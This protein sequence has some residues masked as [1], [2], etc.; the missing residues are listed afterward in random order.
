VPELKA[1]PSNPTS[2]NLPSELTE[3][4]ILEAISDSGY[5]LQ[6][7]VADQLRS[8]S[9]EEVQQEWSYLDQ[10]S[11]ENRPIDVL[12]VKWLSEEEAS[13]A[14]S[15]IYPKLALVVE[16]KQSRL[17]Y[18]FFLS[19]SKPEVENFPLIVGL[20]DRR[21]EIRTDDSRSTWTVSVLNVLSMTSH[22]FITDP[23]Y[24]TS[25]SKCV[26]KPSGFELSGT[27]P[28]HSLVL[29]ILKAVH[30]FDTVESPTAT[31][32]YFHCHLTIGLGVV[33]APMVGMYP[34]GNTGEL[35]RLPWVRVVKHEA[36]ETSNMHFRKG[37][38][39][40][41]IVHKDFLQEYLTNHVIPFASIFSVLALKHQKTLISGK[42]YATGMEKHWTSNIEGRLQP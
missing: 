1:I 7:I 25:F 10:D 21:V 9:F 6:T 37:L 28:F 14:H 22:T 36:D 13:R 34:T 20:K 11:G 27:E 38:F 41:D 16:C 8:D 29:P 12:A 4:D 30:H 17:P 32:A 2:N 18:V 31:A 3:A 19:S 5:P 26:R 23:E 35:I 24:C 39:A 15:H 40:I 33:N 42:G